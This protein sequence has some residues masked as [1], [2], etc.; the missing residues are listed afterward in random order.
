MALGNSFSAL[1]VILLS[2]LLFASLAFAQDGPGM[3]HDG[4]AMNFHRIGSQLAAGG[5]FVGDGVSALKE[6]GV[7]IVVDVQ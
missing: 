2:G 6:Q 5:H 1:R 7:T 4:P 3:A